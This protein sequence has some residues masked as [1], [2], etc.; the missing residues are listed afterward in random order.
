MSA[1]ARWRWLGGAV[2]LAVLALA[3]VAFWAWRDYTGA[4][5]LAASKTL[6]IPRGAGLGGVAKELAQNGVI[7]HPWTFI[8]GVFTDRRL[9]PLKAGEYEFPAAVSPR[10]AAALIASGRVVQHRVTVPEGLTSAEIVALLRQQPALDGSI[11]RVPPEGSLLPNTY[12]Y[13]LDTPRAELL[14]RMHRAMAR[15]VAAAWRDRSSGLPLASPEEAL[16]LASIVERETAREDERPH[17]AA[18]Y[19]NRLKLGMKLQ[20]DPTVSYALTEGGTKP[21]DHPLGHEDLAID[22]PYNTYLHAGLPPTPIDNPGLASL[23]AALHPAASDDLYFVADGNG[24]HA[25]SRTLAEH[26]RHVEE[27]RHAHAEGPG[28]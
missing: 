28:K 24:G 5:P 4:G 21:L 10:A 13:V 23:R 22:S 3:A 17:V 8:A 18:V 25:F 6:V 27:L 7:T 11:D 2:L 19:L 9:G 16:T 14:A 1:P 12:F 15:A 20:A 26:N